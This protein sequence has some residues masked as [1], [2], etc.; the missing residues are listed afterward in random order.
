MGEKLTLSL[1]QHHA[2]AKRLFH[3]FDFYE[4]RCH[5]FLVAML[6]FFFLAAIIMW[7]GLLG[8]IFYVLGVV[9]C[10]IS[11]RYMLILRQIRKE[12]KKL[13]EAEIY[14]AEP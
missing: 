6:V 2:Q 4:V 3:E 1:E 10:I 7:P 13:V 5:L 8:L 12:L 14:D 11:I 9:S